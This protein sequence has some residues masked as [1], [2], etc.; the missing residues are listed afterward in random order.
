MKRKDMYIAELIFNLN[1]FVEESVIS[2]PTTIVDSLPDSGLL[3]QKISGD[4]S[5]FTAIYG[6]PDVMMR[7]AAEYSKLKVTR[8]DHLCAEL[9]GDF[10]NLHNGL[11]VVKLSDAENIESSLEPPI[12]S[13]NDNYVLNGTTYI[14]PVEFKFGTLNFVLSE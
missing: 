9:I 5:A 8:Y 4:Y 2:R 3:F 10:L 13:D 6:K 1:R 14:M 11:F 7:F 12:I